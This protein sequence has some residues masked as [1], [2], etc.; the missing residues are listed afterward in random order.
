LTNA[1]GTSPLVV[2]AGFAALA[3]KGGGIA[4]GGKPLMFSGRP[5]VTIPA[6]AVVV[7]DPVDLKLPAAADLA[8][9]IHLPGDVTGGS[10]PVTMHSAGLE[11]NY[12]STTGNVV[13]RSEL[14]GATTTQSVY[15]LSR[16]EVAAAPQAMAI[17]TFGDSITDGTRS[18]P[19]T[20]RRW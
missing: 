20:N 11:T 13:G 5:S 4:P 15:F 8:I 1:F 16:V 12:I 3:V 2:D 9:D 10:S 14:T 7:S 17:A 6:G 19:D 18:T